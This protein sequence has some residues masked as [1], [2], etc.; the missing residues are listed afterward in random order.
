MPLGVLDELRLTAARLADQPLR[1]RH[2][3]AR[4]PGRHRL[5]FQ[6]ACESDV[7]D[8]RRPDE[9]IGFPG[10]LV[11]A[12]VAGVIAT[13]WPV[14]DQAALLLTL[15]FYRTWTPGTPPL[16]A[17]CAAQRWL[18]DATV[19]QL[20]ALQAGRDPGPGAPQARRPFQDAPW[21][22]ACFSYTGV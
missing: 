13:Q 17:F 18:R 14:R 11:Q 7:P 19:A 20:V 4:P 2:L 21:D 22:W 6:S 9:V 8:Q 5:A 16:T 10:A 1:V 3:L 15:R 12:G